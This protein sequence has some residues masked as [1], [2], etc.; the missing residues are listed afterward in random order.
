MAEGEDRVS[1]LAPA[2]HLRVGV[3]D[4]GKVP[5]RFSEKVGNE[6]ILC[7]GV[8]LG[9]NPASSSELEFR[10]FRGVLR[11]VLGEGRRNCERGKSRS[12]LVVD[13]VQFIGVDVRLWKDD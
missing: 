5:G 1:A 11:G 8:W 9:W 13:V 10:A 3:S 6:A 7:L 4:E 2:N 12:G